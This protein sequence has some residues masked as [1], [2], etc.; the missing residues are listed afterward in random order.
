MIHIRCAKN[1][2]LNDSLK[3]LFDKHATCLFVLI[4]FT[5]EFE[6]MTP[7]RKL[8]IQLWWY[9]LFDTDLH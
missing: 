4:N 7:K 2:I 9:L 1:K 3:V 8:A 5:M 6:V